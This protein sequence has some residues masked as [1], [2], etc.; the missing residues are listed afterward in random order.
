[1]TRP[2]TNR[3]S[4]NK[5]QRKQKGENYLRNNALEADSFLLELSEKP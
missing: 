3:T 4:K 1:M 2:G 5:D